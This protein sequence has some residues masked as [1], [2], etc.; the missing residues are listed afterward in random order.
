[1][2]RPSPDEYASYFGRYISLVDSD[3]IEAALAA[4]AR[5]TL[6]LLGRVTERG[7]LYRYEPGKWS[8]K[9]VLGH[10]SDCERVFAYRALRIGRGDTTPLSGFEQDDFVRGARFDSTPWE[11]LRAEFETVRAATL[12]L[13]RGFSEDAWL[14]RGTAN[15][16]E[17]S[18][19]AL[20]YTIAGHELY[21]RAILQARYGLGVP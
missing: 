13:A 4:Q 3:D 5:D 12:H 9:E 21:H 15:D 19:R 7:S 6:S 2:A 20:V 16:V 11:E 1:V 10:I 17:M 14:R 8:V 18:A